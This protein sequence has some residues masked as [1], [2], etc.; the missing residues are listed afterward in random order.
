MS[1]NETQHALTK[2]LD[3]LNNYTRTHIQLVVQWFVFFATANYVVF[4]LFAVQHV[5]GTLKSPIPLYVAAGLFCVVNGIAI[6]FCIEAGHWFRSTGERISELCKLRQ[7][8]QSNSTGHDKSPFPHKHYSRVT[9]AMAFTIGVVFVA[10]VIFVVVVA[11]NT[12]SGTTS[13]FDFW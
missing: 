5:Q 10:W 1:E 13:E 3:E 6:L 7:G 12:G 4:G 2:E 9:R 8:A 11:W